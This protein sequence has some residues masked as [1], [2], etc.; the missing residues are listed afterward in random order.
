M[1]RV[2]VGNLDPRTQKEALA[3]EAS[4]FGKLVD[5]WIARNPPGFAFLTF[6]DERDAEDCVR[7]MNDSK[8]DGSH[9]KCELSKSHGGGQNERQGGQLV[10]D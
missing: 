6:E 3:D 8:I 5:V 1:A 9:V 7:S 2:Y 10:H 4:R